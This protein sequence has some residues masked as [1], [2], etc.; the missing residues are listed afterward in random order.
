MFIL[1]VFS[2]VV[3]VAVLLSAEVWR[4]RRY[5][6]ESAIAAAK[7]LWYLVKDLRLEKGGCQRIV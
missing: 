3:T 2:F 5:T 7:P 6:S 4:L 1:Q